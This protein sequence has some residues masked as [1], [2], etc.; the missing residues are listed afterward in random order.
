MLVEVTH[1]RSHSPEV[2]SQWRWSYCQGEAEFGKGTHAMNLNGAARRWWMM[3]SQTHGWIR[4]PTTHG[5]SGRMRILVRRRFETSR[6][7]DGRLIPTWM[8]W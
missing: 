2:D 3:S 5:A 4:C 6:E 7:P 8:S 1:E